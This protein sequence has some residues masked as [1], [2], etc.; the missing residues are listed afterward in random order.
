VTVSFNGPRCTCGSVGCIEAYCSGWALARDAQALVDAGRGRGILRAAS[1]GTVDA[2]VIGAA[3]R[4]SD[5]EAVA[6]IEQAGYALGAGIGAFINIFN[7]ELV[8]LGGG[9]MRL[10][11]PLFKAAERAARAFA[12]EALMRDTSIVPS[13]LGSRSGVFGA[14]ALAFHADAG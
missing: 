2:R 12:F 4:A 7:P 3:A 9:V 1:G 13:E 6:L 5:P 11:D 14:A 10:G 8:V